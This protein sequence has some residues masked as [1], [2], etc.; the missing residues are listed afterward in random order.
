MR[1][2]ILSLL[3][4]FTLVLSIG[5][6]AG[7]STKTGVE[8]PEGEAS[9]TAFP[10]RDITMIVPFG[11][12]GATDLI[13]RSLEPAMEE[14][15]GVQILATNMPGGASA[16]GNEYVFAAEHD[17]YTILAQPTDITSIA[18]MGQSKLNHEDWEFLYINAAVPGCI[19]VSK[20]SPYK[21]LDD[22][23]A[24]MKEKPLSV[25]TSD[26]GC[27]FTRCLGLMIQQESGIINPE[28]VPS[29]GGAN[30][31]LSAVK[32]D[33]DAA[34]CGLPE[35]IDLVRSGD[36]VVLTYFGAESLDIDGINIPCVSEK[37]PQ[38]EKYLPFGGWVSMAVP[39]DT[40]QDVIDTLRAAVINAAEKQE[41]L[42]FL[43]SKT[44]VPVGLSG[45]EAN[46]WAKTSTSVNAW[47][48]YDMGFT[49]T[50]PETLGI[51]RP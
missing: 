3:L 15:L 25:A 31:S 17:G 28:L 4:V 5:L 14:Y 48:L 49:N 19:A 38:L 41:Y 30:A 9:G 29:G 40:P 27:A 16:V 1:K 42:D 24:A 8:G 22:F 21:T 33:V 34:A 12:G 23:I 20:D 45:E 6:L 50:S 10:E 18:V 47:L 13:A 32:G 2:K 36:L 37:Y 51:P 39:K 26:S 43:A 7:C 11:A 44:F 35:C 46:E